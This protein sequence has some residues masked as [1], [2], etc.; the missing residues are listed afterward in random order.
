MRSEAEIIQTVLSEARDREAQGRG[1][2]KD[3][4]L[5]RLLN[6]DDDVK[7]ANSE[8]RDA[9]FLFEVTVKTILLECFPEYF[10]EEG[11]SFKINQD[12]ARLP[13]GVDLLDADL[14]YRAFGVLEMDR[15]KFPINRKFFDLNALDELASKDH[16]PLW[17]VL[18][19]LMPI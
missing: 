5:R 3:F 19:S 17:V 13:A 2:K 4:I 1:D 12:P 11:G 14:A 9:N 8:E 18:K 7:Q 10:I 15:N 16:S 6:F